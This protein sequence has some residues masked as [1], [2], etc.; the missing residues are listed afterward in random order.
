MAPAL[1]DEGAYETLNIVS[2][3]GATFYA[4]I[5]NMWGQPKDVKVWPDLAT[6][7]A[8]KEA[9]GPMQQQEQQT[10]KAFDHVAM[11]DLTELMQQETTDLPSS[12]GYTWCPDCLFYL[13]NGQEWEH[14]NGNK[15][16][17][18]VRRRLRGIPVP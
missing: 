2:A 11:Q 9:A 12:D 5:L 3:G 18:N 17:K 15:H 4:L 7:V 8:A 14:A 16:R 6:L 13:R 10:I 1:E